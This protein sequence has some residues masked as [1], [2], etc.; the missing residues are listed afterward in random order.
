VVS[1][2]RVVIVDEPFV[3][4]VLG[5]RNPVGRLLRYVAIERSPSPGPDSPWYEIVGV[6]PNL[7]IVSGYGL[8]GVYHATARSDLFPAGLIVHVR[9]DPADFAPRLRSVAA[10]VD[11][12]V[13]VESLVSLDDIARVEAGALGWAVTAIVAA[14]LTAL[15]LS[16]AGIY[17]VMSFT[18]SRRTREIGI[19]VA[20]GAKRTRLVVG[21]LRRPILQV[22]LGIVAG[23]LLL[24]VA[25]NAF[26][27]EERLTPAQYVLVG[28][29][30]AAML[31]VCLLS[32]V[33]PTRR[34]LAIEPR[35][36]L[37]VE[38]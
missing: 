13:R 8:G 10:E 11:A 7:G 18:V 35:E 20:L 24:V 19:R 28:L 27:V 29:H 14:T 16:L 3:E 30:C 12:A 4:R 17:S 32:C 37:N 21:T 23:G 25:A 15:M 31:M 6:V 5:G 1:G 9:T 33:V 2:A 34:A 26:F 38:G 36:A 22:A